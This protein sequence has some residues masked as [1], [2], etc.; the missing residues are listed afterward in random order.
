[1]KKFICILFIILSIF[2]IFIQK[3]ISLRKKI[4]QMLIIGFN[5]TE[6]KKD[7]PIYQDIVK[8]RIS[9]VI[10][11][12]K[13]AS[14]IKSI[15]GNIDTTKN[16]KSPEQLKKL[17]SDMRQLSK[18]KLFFA[19]D[20]EGGKISRLPLQYGFN[21]KTLSH[22][23]LGEINDLKTTYN[24]AKKI[25][26]TLKTLGINL[27]F[28]PC[29]DLA[30]NENSK[31]IYQKERSFSKN[32]HIVANHAKEFIKAHREEKI[33]TSIKH[34][35]GHGSAGADT[36]KSAVDATNDWQTIE[37]TPYKILI[38]DGWADSV[39]IS[40][41]FNKNFDT[42][43]PASLSSKTIQQLLKNGLY[44]KGLIISDDLQMNAITSNYSFET[45]IIKAINAG[46]DII[47]IG[48]NLQYDANVAKKFN[49][50]V[51]QAIKNGKI[52]RKRINEAYQKIIKAKKKL[53]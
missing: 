37:I 11:F 29:I 34:F 24:E 46:C 44:F 22:K 36:H 16:V 42:E 5:G 33:I 23:E 45:A 21:V 14:K 8:E 6:L 28:A 26:T 41:I 12:S 20:Q 32:P 2:V 10:I 3:E 27:N 51:Y 49:N 38:Q 50:T 47:I 7:N 19:I 17:I 30:L 15:D 39:M 53:Y 13:D 52:K 35:P 25:A 1:M 31:V 40:H 48:N 9:G 18:R 4:S 43:F